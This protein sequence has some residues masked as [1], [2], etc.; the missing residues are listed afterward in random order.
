MRS[1]KDGRPKGTDRQIFRQIFSGETKGAQAD[2]RS[3]DKHLKH[4]SLGLFSPASVE[5]LEL[6]PIPMHRACR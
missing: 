6:I 4:L 2:G 5:S 3:I 1:H